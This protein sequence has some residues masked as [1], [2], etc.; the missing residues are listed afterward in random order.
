V[1][2][3]RLARITDGDRAIFGWSTTVSPLPL[4]RVPRVAA[5]RNPKITP[6]PPPLPFPYLATAKGRGRA[7]PGRRSALAAV[8]TSR[9]LMCGGG[10]RASLLGLGRGPIVGGLS[11]DARAQHNNGR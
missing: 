4:F 9:P 10:K 8:G 7:K 1:T 5:G 2:E 3:L 11:S 6:P